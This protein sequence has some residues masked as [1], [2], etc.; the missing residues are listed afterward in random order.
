MTLNNLIET[1]RS[2]AQNH[3]QLN[4]FGRGDVS[5][6]GASKD[7]KYPLMW[8]GV[9]SARY[10][11]SSIYYSLQLIFADLIFDDKKNE[12]EVQSDMLLVG[13]DTV[14]YLRENPDFDFQVDGDVTI[15]F[16]TERFTDLTAG[17]VLGITLRDP[18]PLD[19]CVIPL[20]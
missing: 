7:Q 4:D 5:E 17:C 20:D 19:R 1:L 15:D 8:V 16:F 2:Y 10:S 3:K 11:T 9:S 14:A 6:L 12:V 13:L 18:K